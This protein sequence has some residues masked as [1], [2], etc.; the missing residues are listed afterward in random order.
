MKP[1]LAQPSCPSLR[2]RGLTRVVVVGRL[3]AII[4]AWTLD[5][6][7]WQSHIPSRVERRAFVRFDPQ[8]VFSP[9]NLSIVWDDKGEGVGVSGL[10]DGSE[11]QLLFQYSCSNLRLI[12]SQQ[13]SPS[14]S[15]Y[16]SLSFTLLPES[17]DIFWVTYSRHSKH[18]LNKPTTLN[19]LPQKFIPFLSSWCEHS[20]QLDILE[21]FLTPGEST[22]LKIK[23]TSL[24]I[25]NK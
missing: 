1:D 23:T 22:F 14:L 25:G 17:S 10:A 18:L 7:A 15:F 6:R 19:L 4:P 2:L 12:C 21:L 16:S 3:G 9:P 20:P 13:G 11:L 24:S 8:S 5:S